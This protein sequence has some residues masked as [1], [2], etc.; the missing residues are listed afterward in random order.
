M[1]GVLGCF[2]YLCAPKLIFKIKFMAQIE[3]RLSSK[4]QKE[5]GMCEVL[6]RF[7]QGYSFN[8][9]AKTGIFVSPDYFEYYIDR[10]KTESLGVKVPFSLVT[11]TKEKAEKNNYVLRH[12]GLIV[13]KQRI[14]TPDVKYH[15]EQ[16]NRIDA[17][18][19]TIIQTFEK[20]R[21]SEITS[22]W[23]Q[24][25]C[26]KFINPDKFIIKP[27]GRKSFY[28][29]AED[30]IAKRKIS[31]S[32]AKVFR[33]L[34]R[35]VARFEG[36]IR[37]TE[38]SHRNFEFD[39]NTV[40]RDDIENFIEYLRHEYSLS[41]VY[42]DL[43]KKLLTNYPA[44]VTK[45]NCKL[46]DRGEN[47]VIKGAKRLKSLFMWFFE[48]GFTKNRPFDGINIG[49]EK[50][51]T[52]YYITIDERN[53][54]AET[55]LAAAYDKMTDEERKGISKIHLPEYGVQRDIFIFQCFVGCRVGDLLRL[56]PGNIIDSILV[57]TP[58]KTKDNGDQAVQARIPLH[59]KAME[60]VEK[61]RGCSPDGLLFPF[62]SA[63]KYNDS[64]KKIFKL[65]GI[66]RNVIIRNAKTGE[67]ELVAI[68]TV[69]SS[70]LA[71]RTFIGNAYFKVSDPNL[72]GRM[73]GHVDGSRAFKR[74]RNIEDE[75][76]KSVIDLIG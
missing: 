16:S 34:M 47:T 46:E 61:Y 12:S 1:L 13:I 18:K 19:K 69:A 32:H 6:I 26:D 15:R 66:T 44:S 50:V 75:T 53:T 63:Q 9:R 72:I 30:Y 68:D 27:E 37:A 51:G 52:P 4:L 23:L 54:I 74:Y 62:I 41:Q 55:D 2:M 3:L 5:T 36:F 29:L 70:H 73:S 71:R 38:P 22:E 39:I 76:L 25:V 64:I 7:V 43:Y 57:Y 48:E 28:E 49:T 11:A 35:E 33:V 10:A 56:K 67:N 20:D 40:T 60:L 58:H 24:M 59:P 65:A 21:D 14:E 42:P 31:Y 45:G 17:L 8:T